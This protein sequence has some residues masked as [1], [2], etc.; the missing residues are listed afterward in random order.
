[1]AVIGIRD[2]GSAVATAASRLPTA[3]CAS[4]S[5]APSHS[6]AFVN[7]SAPASTIIT[8]T[9]RRTIVLTPESSQARRDGRIQEDP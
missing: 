6:I 5:F 9:G 7:R 8:L 2:S 4:S 3:P 1:M